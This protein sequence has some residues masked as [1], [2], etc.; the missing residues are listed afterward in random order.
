[1][2]ENLKCIFNADLIKEKVEALSDDIIQD[3][4]PSE[5]LVLICVLNGAFKFH[6]Q[7]LAELT[8]RLNDNIYV[9]FIKVSSYGDELVSTGKISLLADLSLDVK[10]KNILIVEDIID[11]GNTIKFLYKHFLKKEPKSIKVATLL[12]KSTSIDCNLVIDYKCFK[13]DD[14]FAV[15]YG[16]DYMQKYRNLEGIYNIENG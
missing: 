16:L 11:T 5:D 14:F 8:K 13:I 9:D 2:N 1:M 4:D 6:N 7:L 3:H 10:N 12:Y 15:G